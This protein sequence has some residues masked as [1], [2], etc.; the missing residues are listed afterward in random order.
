MNI[1]QVEGLT[2]IYG[3]GDAAVTALGGVTFSVNKGEFVAV[4]GA[5]GSGKSTLMH[6]IGGVERPTGG[7]VFVD[8]MDI[9]SLNE[10]RL[11]IFRRRNIGLIYQFYNL[12]PTLTAEENIIL[13]HL[14]DNRK[15]GPKKLNEILTLLSLTD[16][17][18]H[19]PGQ[20]SG[21]QQQRVS[22]GRALVN[23]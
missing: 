1:L 21:G 18:D 23:D 8:G 13:P 2:K 4:V 11:A 15:P 3:K 9:F 19:L 16:R 5:S 12:I 20:L 10:S 17:R 22:I 7:K 6:L 14:L